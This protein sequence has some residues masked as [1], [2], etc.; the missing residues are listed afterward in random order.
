M[1]ATTGAVL[2][3]LLGATD[4][5][6]SDL[7]KPQKIAVLALAGAVLASLHKEVYSDPLKKPTPSIEAY[8]YID[9][10]RA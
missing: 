4:I 5:K 8:K 10:R 6:I 7:S 3:G 2:G 1:N 9:K